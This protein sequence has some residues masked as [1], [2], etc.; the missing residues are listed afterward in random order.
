MANGTDPGQLEVDH[1]DRDSLNNNP[2]NLRLA[3][4]AQNAMNRRATCINSSGKKGVG[5]N[6][7]CNKWE[8]RITVGRRKK[9]L[10]NFDSIEDAVAAYKKAA[11]ELHG[12][13]ASYD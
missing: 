12:E 1:I 9:F 11:I 7:I 6:K 4:H 5:W 10:G 13:F 3:T 8:A 2:E